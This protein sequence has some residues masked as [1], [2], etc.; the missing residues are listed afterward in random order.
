MELKE[1]IEEQAKEL[2]EWY[3]EAIKKLNPKS[4]N[5]NANKPYGELTE[6]QK[7]IDRYIAK[8]IHIKMWGY[9]LYG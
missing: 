3:L 6:E 5:E 9:S 8:K 2:H 1:E 7:E 4:F